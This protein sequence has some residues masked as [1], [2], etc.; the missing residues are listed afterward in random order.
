MI[1]AHNKERAIAAGLMDEDEPDMPLNQHLTESFRDYVLAHY[2]VK[3]KS[4]LDNHD[5]LKMIYACEWYDLPKTA[6]GDRIAF[7]PYCTERDYIE[8]S[9]ITQ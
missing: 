5:I 8:L 1:D 6:H 2:S 7:H 9:Y 3:D 4:S